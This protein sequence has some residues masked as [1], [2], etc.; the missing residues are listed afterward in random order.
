MQ[1][2]LFLNGLISKNKTS[3]SNQFMNYIK[4]EYLRKSGK[5]QITEI[6][7][8]DTHVD[9][10]LNSNNAHNYYNLVDSL[11]WINLLRETDKLIIFTPEIN[12]SPSP[13]VKNFLDSI[14]VAKETFNYSDFSNSQNKGNL[15][16][17][18][19]LIITTRGSKKAWYK[20]SSA[21]NWIKQIWKFLRVKKVLTLEI[22]GLNLEKNKKLS[23]KELIDKY[24]KKID[25]IINKFK[26]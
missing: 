12:F 2:I 9:T 25:K 21:R 17:L 10:I 7:L 20:W 3:I 6:D 15:T 4:K 22:N 13:V 18:D 14:L 24:Q 5:S 11:K 16:H 26:R 23:D 19:V 8:N 1:K